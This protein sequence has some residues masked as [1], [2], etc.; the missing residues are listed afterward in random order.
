MVPWHRASL[1]GSVTDWPPDP[2][3]D[4]KH[5]HPSDT[6]TFGQMV[7]NWSRFGFVTKVGDQYAETERAETIPERIDTVP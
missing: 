2:D 3:T 6:P 5:Q 4:P 7:A 1:D